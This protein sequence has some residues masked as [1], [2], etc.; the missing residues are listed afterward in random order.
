MLSDLLGIN[1]STEYSLI[2]LK[3]HWLQYKFMVLSS[4]IINVQSYIKACLHN[5]DV[6][7]Q[8]CKVGMVAGEALK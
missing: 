8:N 4:K 7:V 3:N 5:F 2:W 1:K 6:L